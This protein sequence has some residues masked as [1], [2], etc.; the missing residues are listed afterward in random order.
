MNHR[1]FGR[2]FLNRMYRVLRNSLLIAVRMSLFFLAVPAIMLGRLVPAANQVG[3]VVIK[4]DA[5]G[6]F[7]LSLDSILSSA[8]NREDV[9]ITGGNVEELVAI[10]P[11]KCRV[12]FVDQRRLNSNLV[13]RGWVFFRLSRFTALKVI[14]LQRSRVLHVSD[15]MTLAIR[16]RNKVG[17]ESDTSSSSF[18]EKLISSKFYQFLTPINNAE[19]HE[20][21]SLSRLTGIYRDVPHSLQANK[22]SHERFLL[23][24]ISAS[25]DEKTFPHHALVSC[26]SRLERVPKIIFVGDSRHRSTKDLF[27]SLYLES[28]WLVG[29]TNLRELSELVAR[30]IGVVSSDSLLG[31]LAQHFQRPYLVLRSGVHW[32]RFFPYPSSPAGSSVIPQERLCHCTS[33]C[34]LTNPWRRVRPCL[35][36]LPHYKISEEIQRIIDGSDQR[37]TPV[38]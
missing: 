2:Q 38:A 25:T 4:V 29:L 6:D 34:L 31:H 7:V 37:S 23:I 5:A 35:E 10:F 26:L 28:E 3:V 19:E 20:T 8:M 1:R 33:Q 18:I 22:I 21:T 32:D 15:Q 9:L 17:V 16:S 36:A 14:N 13:Y 12:M 24:S 30:S 11:I 27:D